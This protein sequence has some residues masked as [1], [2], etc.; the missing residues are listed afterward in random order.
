MSNFFKIGKPG[1]SGGG[2]S[3]VG[4]YGSGQSCQGYQG[5][6]GQSTPAGGK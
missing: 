6:G 5:G 4:Y 1:G 2:G 3:C